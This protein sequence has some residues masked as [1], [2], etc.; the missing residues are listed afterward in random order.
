MARRDHTTA[1]HRVVGGADPGSCWSSCWPWPPGARPPG[2][3]TSRRVRR[4]AGRR[5]VRRPAAARPPSSPRRS[6]HRRGWSCRRS[7][8]RPRSPRPPAPGRWPRPGSAPPLAPYLGDPDLGPH[9]V[10]RGRA[11]RAG[12]PAYSS[13]QGTATPGLHDQALHHDGGAAGPGARAQ[14]HHHGGRRRPAAGRAGRRRRPLP[15]PASRSTDDTPYPARADVVTLAQRTAKTLRRQGRRQVSVGYDDSLFTGPAANPTWEPDYVPDGVVS[16]IVRALGRRGSGRSATAGSPTRRRPPPP[17][18]PSALADAG[19][20]VQGV[21]EPGRAGAGGARLAAM[22]SAPLGEIVERILDVSDN[23]AAEVLLRHVGPGR[24]PRRA[25]LPPASRV[26]SG[27]W[28]RRASTSLRAS[29]TTAAGCPAPTGSPRRPWSTCSALAASPDHPSCAPSSPG[30]RWPASPARWPTGST[31]R[32]RGARPGAGQDRHPDRGLLA[33]RHRGR[34]RRR[35]DG[36]RADEPT[37]SARPTPSTRARPWT[38][39]PPRWAPAGAVGSGAAAR[40]ALHRS[41]TVGA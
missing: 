9:V 1:V 14:L 39:P 8:H 6:P 11:A 37:G 32:P 23:E 16:P 10:A 22:P 18:S 27:C 25:R 41:T 17:R 28:A 19:I 20:D 29:S 21:P 4:P 38:T 3:S 40:V 34:T 7:R 5:L 12:E 35:T 33:G 13:G 2:A 26:S 31:G 30:C 24:R 36:L 15:R